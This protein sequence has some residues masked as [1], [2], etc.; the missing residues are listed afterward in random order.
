MKNKKIRGKNYKKAKKLIKSEL[1][2]IEKAIELVKKADYSTYTSSIEVKVNLNVDAKDSEQNVRFT[3]SIPHP[4][5]E[6]KKVLAFG[7]FKETKFNT[8]KVIKGTEETVEKILAGKFNAKKDFD[9]VIC[10]ASFMPKIAKAARILGPKGLM[11]NPK[12]NT[13]GELDKI[14]PMLDKGQVEVR[15]QPSN[16]VIHLVIGKI[17]DKDT[18]LI[19]NYKTLIDEINKHKPTK[20][21]KIF[22]QSVYIKSSQSPSIG[23]KAE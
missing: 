5:G 22:I 1:L 12:T 18:N 6:Q 16:K 2:E 21:K 20:V 4:F 11:P 19:E 14:L 3:C 13:V 8:L 17:T 23:V 10:D 9:L 7:E 15:L